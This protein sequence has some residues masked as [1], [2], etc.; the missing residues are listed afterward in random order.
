MRHR[1][2]VASQHY[3]FFFSAARV[4][5]S[6]AR[7]ERVAVAGHLQVR[8]AAQRALDRVGQRAL[9]AADRGDVDEGGGERGAFGMQVKVVVHGDQLTGPRPNRPRRRPRYATSAT[10]TADWRAIAL[11]APRSAATMTATDGR[12][13]DAVRATAN[14]S[15]ARSRPAGSSRTTT[16]R[17]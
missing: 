2:D 9:L 15:L 11:A 10:P 17:S 3:S 7:D 8:Q 1:V 14:T 5:E 13:T 4:P 16:R 6:R 12:I